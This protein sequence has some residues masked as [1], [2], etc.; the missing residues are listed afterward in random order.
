MSSTG[1][2]AAG[3]L[4]LWATVALEPGGEPEDPAPAEGPAQQPKL[5]Q[6]HEARPR[7]RR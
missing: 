6:N 7:G 4:W 5:S 2:G 1:P 3:L